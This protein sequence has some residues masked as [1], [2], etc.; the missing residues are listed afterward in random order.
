MKNL[1]IFENFDYKNPDDFEDVEGI[2]ISM[3]NMRKAVKV[4]VGSE[5]IELNKDEAKKIIAALE[6]AIRLM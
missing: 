1:R 2:D 5:E 4:K 3:T 6:N